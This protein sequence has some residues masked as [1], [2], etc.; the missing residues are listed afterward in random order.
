[1]LVSRSIFVR[2]SFVDLF[3]YL[4]PEV[5]TGDRQTDHFNLISTTKTKFIFSHKIFSLFSY[6]LTSYTTYTSASRLKASLPATALAQEH[7]V[8]LIL[9]S[10]VLEMTDVLIIDLATN[11]QMRWSIHR[12]APPVLPAQR[13]VPKCSQLTAV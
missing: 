4:F 1:M 5:Q 7:K 6:Y 12:P 13:L 3:R 2:A 9:A 10:S 11:Y 8:A